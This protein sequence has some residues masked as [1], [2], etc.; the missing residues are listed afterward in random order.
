MNAEKSAKLPIWVKFGYG[1]AEGA[2]SMIFTNFY[3][4]FMIFLT[5]VVG[6]KPALAGGILM[7][8]TLWDAFLDPAIGIWS[9]KL[10]W[11]WGRRRPLL[12]A[13]ALPYGLVGWLMFTDFNLGKTLTPIY[14]VAIVF[15]HSTCFAFLEVPHLSLC[16]EMTPDYDERTSLNAYRAVWSQIFSIVSGGLTLVLAQY[17]GKIYGSEKVGWSLMGATLGLSC[18][19]LILLT[20]RTTRG[21]ELFPETVTVKA[22]DILDA[23]RK[24]PSFLYTVLMYT[25][26]IAGMSVAGAVMAYF[27]KYIM[28]F[29]ES[30]S[31]VAFGLLFGCTVVWVPAISY[32]SNKLGKRTAW[33]IFMGLWT[34]VQGVGIMLLKPGNVIFYYVLIFFASAG[35]VGVYMIAWT[36]MPDV[37]EVDEFHTGQRRE[38]LHYGFFSF[39]QKVGAAI[40]LWGVGEVLDWVGYVPNVAQTARALNGIKMLYGWGTGFLLLVSVLFCYLMPMTKKKHNALRQAIQL[41]KEGKA[42]DQSEFEDLL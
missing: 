8:R 14:F 42:Y 28:A 13:V 18:T 6:I 10:K 25:F 36:I 23:I 5:D 22:K 19:P 12:L 16:A 32:V 11:K 31:S 2:N 41:K 3:L 4:F 20:W 38:G 37:I 39:V 30:K 29:S 26:G 35:V 34:L 17:F 40:A 15:F 7:I 24:N 9:D 27:L 21:Y 33:F 1:A